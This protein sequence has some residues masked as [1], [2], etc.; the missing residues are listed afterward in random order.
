M[1]KNSLFIK[2]TTYLLGM[3]FLILILV[4]SVFY[5]KSSELFK[6]NVSGQTTARI[7]T[8]ARYIEQYVSQLKYT[9]NAIANESEVVQFAQGQE[10]HSQISIRNWL[11][12]FMKSNEHFVSMTIVTKDGRIISSDQNLQ[13]ANS[14]ELMTQ[15]WYQQAID[16]SHN[17]VLLP[18]RLQ[19]DKYVLSISQEIL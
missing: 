12:T 6:E 15:E 9:V 3:L 16:L 2:L 19:N 8:S 17:P 18:S 1:K 11:E 10:N 5:W 13:S 14:N 7:D 4:G